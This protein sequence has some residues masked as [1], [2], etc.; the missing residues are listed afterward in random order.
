MILLVAS[1]PNDWAFNR[2]EMEK[3]GVR[4]DYTTIDTKQLGLTVVWSAIVLAFTADLVYALLN[5]V[6]FWDPL[7]IV[8][9]K[10]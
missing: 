5:E 4:Y 7:L 3:K 10:K 1:N 9:G 6:G 8:L 2:F